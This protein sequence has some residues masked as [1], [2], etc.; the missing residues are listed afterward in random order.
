[1][2]LPMIAVTLCLT[3]CFTGVEGTGKINLSKKDIHSVAPSGEDLLLA[4]I[5][6]P[7]L[8]DWSTGKRFV[9]TDDKFNLII[10]NL[11]AAQVGSGDIVS[12]LEAARRTAPG[13]GE[14]TVIFFESDGK[15]LSYSVD[16]PLAE[17]LAA[18]TYSDIP[19]TIDMDLVASVNAKLSGMKVWTRSALW[20][21]DSLQYKKGRK[22]VPV[23]IENVTIGNSFFP[24]R[25]NFSNSD[26]GKGSFL[27]NLGYSGTESRNF[28]KLFSLSDP[29]N[30][31][32]Q[33]SSEHWEA[34]Q[35]EKVLVG[36][37]KEE[38]RLARGNP[39]EVDTGHNYSN[40]VEIWYYPD[41]SFLQFVD[42]VLVRYK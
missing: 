6:I 39:T 26:Y 28:S 42:G 21:D 15:K 14:M 32:R 35:S 36:M 27:M 37:T 38:C 24:L 30:N 7:V 8:K 41:G 11:E 3:S 4:D 34:I 5:P 10:D 9:V 1:M 18:M 19:M 33:I 16:R 40:A 2:G 12:Y 20:Y 13:G 22:Y 17:A 31:Y 29:R 25:V 23:N